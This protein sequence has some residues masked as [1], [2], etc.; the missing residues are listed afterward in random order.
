MR[1]IVLDTET[2]GLDV[3]TCDLVGISISWE[4]HQAYFIPVGVTSKPE[5]NLDRE[6]VRSALGPIFANPNVAKVGVNLKFDARVLEEQ[7]YRVEGLAFDAMLASYV[8]NPD[9]RQH[10][11][12]ALTK[13][14]LD[15][16]M[17]PFREVLGS[18]EHIGEIDVDS[19]VRYACHDADASWRL[20]AP[21]E[22]R[23]A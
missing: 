23:A 16:T 1:E 19:L 9:R 8:I 13:H 20:R 3:F 18:A 11:L 14:L 22:E 2:T 7:G 17:L 21:L 6:L 12:K 15:E 4:D 5:V 10:G